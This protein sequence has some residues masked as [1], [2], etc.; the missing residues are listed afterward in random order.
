MSRKINLDPPDVDHDD[1]TVDAT[2]SIHKLFLETTKRT[3]EQ[4]ERLT[5]IE[6]Q[7]ARR[8][9]LESRSTGRR[10]QLAARRA[11]MGLAAILSV[12][13]I[14]D[15]AVPDDPWRMENAGAIE[16][17]LFHNETDPIELLGLTIPLLGGAAYSRRR[18]ED[19][20]DEA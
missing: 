17:L 6:E 4:E 12:G 19:E 9:K 11:M 16:L 18:K 7:K 20:D 1:A 10:L 8:S 3:L 15:A 5:K 13:A 14:G 2:E